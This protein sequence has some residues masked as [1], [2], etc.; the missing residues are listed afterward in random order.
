MALYYLYTSFQAVDVTNKYI[1]NK[2]EITV[3]D[4][5]V[6]FNKLIKTKN[7]RMNRNVQIHSLKHGAKW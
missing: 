2:G 1:E 4:R 3:Y 5:I 6:N 7:N